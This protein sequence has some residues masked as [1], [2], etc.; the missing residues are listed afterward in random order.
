ME[1]NNKI[2]VLG[3][4]GLVGS[5]LV[6]KLQSQLTENDA[7]DKVQEK[8]VQSLTKEIEHYKKLV[9][10]L[11]DGLD[12]VTKVRKRLRR[13][14]RKRFKDYGFFYIPHFAMMA[15]FFICI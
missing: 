9:T 13:I 4:K 6:R 12:L 15:Y 3:A 1:K 14:V 5:S 10:I 7:S 8:F 2:M 11:K